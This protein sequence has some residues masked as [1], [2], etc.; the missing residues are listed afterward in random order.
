MERKTSEMFQAVKHILLQRISGGTGIEVANYKTPH[1]DANLKL[2][3]NT[4]SWSGGDNGR[5]QCDMM[6]QIGL[7]V[8][9]I[10]LS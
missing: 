7:F 1:H 2:G 5:G 4:R 8:G 6:H 9:H 3:A 10:Q